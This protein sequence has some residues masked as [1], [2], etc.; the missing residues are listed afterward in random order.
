MA[1]LPFSVSAVARNTPNGLRCGVA[2]YDSG[3]KVAKTHNVVVHTT[4]ECIWSNKLATVMPVRD[5]KT[6]E[7]VKPT[8]A[9]R[10]CSSSGAVPA[11]PIT[12]ANEGRFGRDGV[13][14]VMRERTRNEPRGRVRGAKLDVRIAIAIVRVDVDPS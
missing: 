9:R 4:A 7:A 11:N 12:C 10:P 1:S 3:T 2:S 13:A 5:S 6:A 8:I 14:S